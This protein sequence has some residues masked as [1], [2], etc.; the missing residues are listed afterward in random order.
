MH[1]TVYRMHE[2]VPEGVRVPDAV[3]AATDAEA[4]EIAAGGFT[5]AVIVA[6]RLD[7]AELLA[8]LLP[9]LLPSAAVVVYSPALQPLAEC[10][11]WLQGSREF[12]SIQV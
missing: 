7:P 2:P 1:K 6:P 5:S 12:A 9:L 4:G 8:A 3:I 11:H 10:F